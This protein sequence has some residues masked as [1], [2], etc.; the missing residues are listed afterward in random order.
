MSSKNGD[1]SDK[2]HGVTLLRLGLENFD[3]KVQKWCISNFLHTK[4]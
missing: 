4:C 3:R 1:D 2:H